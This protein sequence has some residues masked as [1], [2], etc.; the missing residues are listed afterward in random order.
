MTAEPDKTRD[1]IRAQGIEQNL[2]EAWELV[3]RMK[4]GIPS[5]PLGRTRLDSL[6]EAVE[7][8][9][10]DLAAIRERLDRLGAP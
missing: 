6:E 7:Q 9:R 10:H 3:D 4:Q 8:I 5:E 1:E 2:R